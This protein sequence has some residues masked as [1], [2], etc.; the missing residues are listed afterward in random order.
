MNGK[1]FFAFL[2]AGLVICGC[3]PEGEKSSSGNPLTAPADYVGA[4][5]KAKNKA[6][7]SL[8]TVG[9]KQAIQLFNAQE[10]RNPKN[11]QELVS[12]GYLPSVP[13]APTGQKFQYNPSTGD[14]K[15]VPQ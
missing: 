9:L 3:S 6:D 15:L 7:A 10:G 4:A 2:A 1:T 5:G 13:A 14:L 12:K 8:S 11:L